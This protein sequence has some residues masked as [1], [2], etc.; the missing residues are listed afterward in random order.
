MPDGDQ[1][2]QPL[3]KTIGFMSNSPELL[4]HLHKR[5][6]SSD[7]WCSRKEGGKHVTVQGRL[8]KGTAIY[9]NKLCRAIIRGMTAQLRRDGLIKNGE[10]GIN[11][12]D[13]DAAVQA[14]LRCPEQGYSGRY[15]DDISH[16]VLRDDL[17][18]EAGQKELEYFCSSGCGSNA[19]KTNLGARF[20]D[21][22]SA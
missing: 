6:H 1:K 20:G 13:D 7:G 12:M 2:G 8:T 14:S 19:P 21:H 4:R 17:V 9:S 10:V 15:R 5:C 18:Q 11:G 16:Q 3:R 22:P